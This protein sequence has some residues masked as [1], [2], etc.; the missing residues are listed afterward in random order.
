MTDSD[1]DAVPV[2]EKRPVKKKAATPRTRRPEE[3]KASTTATIKLES[4]GEQIEDIRAFL[5][6]LVPGLE[7]DNQQ[8]I[9]YALNHTARQCRETGKDK[10]AA[11]PG[12]E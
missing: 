8:V 11:A 3:P 1:K 4:V 10:A 6:K 2:P 5:S 7:P 12:D 9:R